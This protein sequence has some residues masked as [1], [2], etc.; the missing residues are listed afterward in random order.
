MNGQTSEDV[1]SPEKI[2]NVLDAAAAHIE[3]VGWLQDDYYEHGKPATDCRVC[4][5]GAINVAM[6]GHPFPPEDDNA[7]AATS[8]IGDL[9]LEH[10]GVLGF[11]LAAWNDEPHRTQD[12]VTTAMRE[13]AA[14]LRKVAAS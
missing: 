12:D 2:A 3:R 14:E 5:V 9:I 4:S 8:D 7:Y 11:D 13:T 6:F 1:M 10:L